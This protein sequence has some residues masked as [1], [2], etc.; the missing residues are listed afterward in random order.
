MG[1]H[2][3]GCMKEDGEWFTDLVKSGSTFPY[4]AIYK[5]TWISADERISNQIGHV[6]MARKWR[7]CMLE[8]VRVKRETLFVCFLLWNLDL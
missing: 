5:A 4:K 8:D 3:L 2:G 7:T 6:T 1:R